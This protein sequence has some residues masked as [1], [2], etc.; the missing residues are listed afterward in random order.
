MRLKIVTIYCVIAESIH[1]KMVAGVYRTGETAKVGRDFFH[2]HSW[3]EVNTFI[4]K[5][6][7][8][9]V[10]NRD[11]ALDSPLRTVVLPLWSADSLAQLGCELIFRDTNEQDVGRFL[12]LHEAKLVAR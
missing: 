8:I 9:E 12:A 5:T 4:V 7:A 3:I 1:L 6:K 2:R 10:I 11:V